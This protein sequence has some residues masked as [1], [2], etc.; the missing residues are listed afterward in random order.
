MSSESA[1]EDYQTRTERS[2]GHKDWER[3]RERERER[4]RDN[5]KDCEIVVDSE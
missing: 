2:K 3:W 5:D 4:K 1:I